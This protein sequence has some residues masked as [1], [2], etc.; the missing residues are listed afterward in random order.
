MRQ[1]EDETFGARIGAV[2]RRPEAVPAGFDARVRSAIDA[3]DR[4]AATPWLTR[5]REV[6]LSPIAGLAIA[7]SFAGL[8]VL[9]TLGVTGRGLAPVVAAAAPDTVHLVRF[10][11]VNPAASQVALVGDFNGWQGAALE[12]AGDSASGVWSVSLPLA[13]GR[14]EYAFVVDGQRWVADPSLPT[15]HDEFGGEHSVLRLGADHVM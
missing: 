3:E 7:A 10:V 11:L 1:D 4:R 2:L 13:A 14:Y 12:R 8:V 15:A 9:G 5:R 6:R